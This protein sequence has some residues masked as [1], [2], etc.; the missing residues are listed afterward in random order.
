LDRHPAKR[1]PISEVSSDKAVV[2]LDVTTAFLRSRRSLDPGFARM[3]NGVGEWAAMA[4]GVYVHIPFCA[5]RCDYCA[6]A[7]WTD[8][9]HLIDEYVDACITEIRDAAL[10]PATSVFFGGGTPS[11]IPGE[12]LMRILAAIN[13]T[14]DA[15]VTVECNPD[16]VTLELYKTYAKA[17]VNRVSIGVQ[18]MA[19]NVLLSLGRTHN[20]DNVAHA[21]M[22]A[23]EAGIARVNIDLI[24]GAKGESIEQ[25]RTTVE[26]VLALE[27]RPAHI[28]AYGL[29][30][31]AGT[32][33]AKDASR[34]PDDD[35]QADKYLIVDDLLQ[36]AGFRNYEISNWA[37]PGDECKHNMLYWQQENYRGIGCAAH[38]H[39]DGRRWWNIRTPDRYIKSVNNRTNLIA[40][41]ENLDDETRAF[42]K[43]E[44]AL[45]MAEGVSAKTLPVDE[46]EGFVDVCDGRA[47]LTQ[48]GRLMANEIATRLIV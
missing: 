30:I 37:Q 36:Q 3:T 27:P 39:E 24:Y 38:S 2:S 15:E 9:D 25:W 44:L 48:R 14:S 20:P 23:Y 47:I 40:G 13:R 11:L 17:G 5:K 18:S 34:H 10:P 42:E 22:C 41:E 6:F 19:D 7:T 21:V 16:T 43:L 32:P 46:L 28:S 26:A 12:Q 8:R 4:F 35:D 45:R 31:E 1:D 29:T 33:L